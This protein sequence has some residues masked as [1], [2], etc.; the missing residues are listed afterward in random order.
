MNGL[1]E[2]FQ[3]SQTGTGTQ[4]EHLLLALLIAFVVGQL[5]AWCYK[6]TH[7]GVC[8]SRTFTQ[9]VVLIAIVA[10]VSM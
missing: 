3:P 9:P 2:F 5:N 7:R 1:Q 6:W 4:V 10:A 8:Y